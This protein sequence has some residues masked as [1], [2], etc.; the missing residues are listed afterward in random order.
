M[1]KHERRITHPLQR[2]L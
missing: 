1:V 2:A